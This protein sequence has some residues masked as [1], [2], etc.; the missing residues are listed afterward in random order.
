MALIFSVTNLFSQ[1]KEVFKAT[2]YG[3][4]PEPIF[5][6]SIASQI[7]EGTFIGVDENEEAK[8]G[9]PKRRWGNNIIPGKGNPNMD[10]ALVE[11]QK[12]AVQKKG[13]EPLLVFEANSANATPSDPTGAVGP[14]HF[15]GAWNSGFRIFD[16]DGN[17]LTSE[18][19]L[20]TLFPGNNIGD[21]IVLYD[22]EADRFIITEFDSSPNGFNVAICQ[23]SDP[24]NDGWYVYTSGF[25]TGLFPDYPKFS[26]WSDGYYVTSN[27]GGTNKV[28]VME[29]DQMLE[30]FSS[31]FVSLPLPGISTSGFYSPQFFNVTNGDLPPIGNAYVVYLQDDA[32]GGVSEDHLKIWT[33][34]VDWDNAGNSDISTAFQ[35]PTTP[36]VSVFDGGSFSNRPQPN[37]PD[38]DVLQATIMNQAQYRRFDGYN[39]AIFN[40]VV[41]VDGPGELAGIRWYELRQYDEG[42]DWEIYQEGTYISP[43][44]DKDAFSGSMAMDANGNIGMG[45][46]T[47]SSTEKIAI[48]YTGRYATDPL[49][50]M[51]IDETFIA[52]STGNNPSNRLADYVHLTLDPSN[53][54][55]FWHIAEY[56]NT[57]RTDVVAAFQIAPDY[58]NDIGVA[59]ID[60]P[61]D[62]ALSDAEVVSVT[63]FNAG[64]LEQTDIEVSYQVDGGDIITE[65]YSG[66]LEPQ[67]YESFTF[68]QTAD[69]GVVGQTYE[70]KAFTSLDNDEDMQNDTATKLVKFYGPNDLGIALISQPNS[71]EGLGDS[72][73]VVVE[74]MNYGTEDQS[75]IDVSYEFEGST[76]NEVFSGTL[77]FGESAEYSF[78]YD[79][80]MSAPGVHYLKAFTSLIQD[81]DLTNDTAYKTVFN[82]DCIPD[83]SCAFGHEIKR[84]QLG[85]IDNESGCSENAYGDYVDQITDLDVNSMNDFT[86]SASYGNQYVKV[87]IDFNDDFV[88]GA[89]EVVSAF[90]VADGAG[91]GEFTQTE[92]L[93]VP[94]D[95]FLGE[96]LMRVKL[97]WLVPIGDD[98]AC[99]DISDGGETEDYMVNIVQPVGIADL[100]ITDADFRVA[101]LGSNQYKVMMSTEDWNEPLRIDVHNTMGQCVLH[102]RVAKIGNTY[103]YDL[104]MSYAPKG[105]YIIRFGSDE[106]GKVKK[107]VVK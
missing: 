7:E 45:Y 48:Y 93:I 57:G 11:N 61:E 2:E 33:V 37:G 21:P 107:I 73:A 47:V 30:G 38:Q 6:P 28:F 5:V 43:Y 17:P 25:S 23:G 96:H 1:E 51:T 84:V 59:T 9:H 14:N 44:N 90:E 100:S 64:E 31:Q 92:N 78:V 62:G 87:W 40:F 60:T 8:K 72:E 71:G 102:N 58:Q 68:N 75:D 56:F 98:G 29:R 53:D 54:K 20:S 13:R 39:S 35:I 105:M 12:R 55:T 101:D 97:S 82:S 49:G 88:F 4:L 10:D 70:I 80:D 32:W 16:K 65:M 79:A 41:D 50:Q 18:A 67:A 46:T 95:A 66:T 27:I 86:L 36:Y 76:V 63:I 19:S 81:V 99:D 34:N 15:V 106:Y 22:V 103:T 94:E 26:I 91:E 77:S 85:S 83:A 3:V 74:V 69:L 24:V 42:E 89:E 104:D 52:Q